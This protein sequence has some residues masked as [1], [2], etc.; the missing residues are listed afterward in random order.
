MKSKDDQRLFRVGE[1]AKV[2]GRTVRALHLYEELGLLK[3][4]SRSDGGYRLYSSDAIGRVNWISKLQD[5][6]FS[7]PDIQGFVRAWE[8]S[9]SGPDGMQK[10]RA[11]FEEKLR[12]TREAISRMKSLERDLEASLSYLESCSA[13]EPTHVRSDCACCQKGDHR[14]S[15]TPDLVAG[16]AQADKGWDVSLESVTEGSR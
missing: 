7:L 16:L 5:M 8:G 15:A 12:E 13:C 1:L 3:P 10:V 4:V 14:P 6:G 2:V 11:T 9:A